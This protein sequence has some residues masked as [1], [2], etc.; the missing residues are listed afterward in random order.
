[1]PTH[2]VMLQKPNAADSLFRA[3]F[4]PSQQLQ[5]AL[6]LHIQYNF[7][8]LHGSDVGIIE[9]ELAGCG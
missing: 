4:F 9:N 5:R 3:H 2:S 6:N 7:M 1:V 8:D